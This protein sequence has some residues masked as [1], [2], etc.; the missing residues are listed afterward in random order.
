M[1]VCLCINIPDDDL[2]EVEACRRGISEKLL[3]VIFCAM[4][5][6]RYGIITLLYGI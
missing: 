6:V 4:C 5:W 2:V 1:L 3:F